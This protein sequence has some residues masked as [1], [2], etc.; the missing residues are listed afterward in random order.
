MDFNLTSE[1]ISFQESARNFAEKVLAPYAADWDA[2][3][4]FPLEAIQKAGECG[5][6]GVYTSEDVG[7]LGLS[8]LDATLIFEE[9][10]QACPSTAAYIS[11]HNMVTWIIDCF[12]SKQIREKFCP[13]MA[14]AKKLGSYCL[15][16]PGSGSDAASLRTKAIKK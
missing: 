11:I 7:G 15:T 16:E 2:N 10:A 12:G 9:L 5:F 1:Q 14:I 3:K 8:R 13:D 6:C 4:T